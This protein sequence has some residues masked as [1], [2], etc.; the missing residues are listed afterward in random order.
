MVEHHKGQMRADGN[1]FHTHPEAVAKILVGQGHTDPELLAAALLHDVVEDTHAT[2]ADVKLHFGDAVS[3]IVD[4]V[5]D[6]G[7]QE[8]EKWIEDRYERMRLSHEKVLLAGQKDMRV[9]LVK[10]ADRIHNL[11]T[12]DSLSEERKNRLRKEAKEFHLGLAKKAGAHKMAELIE[13][14]VD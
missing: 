1:P 8:G 12:L 6:P 10:T 2:L 11:S 9:F 14:L 13:E 4:A 5:S 3:R 7:T